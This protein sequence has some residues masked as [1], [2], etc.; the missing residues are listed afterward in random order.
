MGEYQTFLLSAHLAMV[1]TAD[2]Q[3]YLLRMPELD[4]LGCQ[5]RGS[6]LQFRDRRSSMRLKA[7]SVE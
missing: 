4:L 7:F 5:R 6:H 3:R 1:S 2:Y